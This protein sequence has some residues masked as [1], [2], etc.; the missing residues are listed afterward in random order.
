M[1]NFC[2]AAHFS[3]SGHYDVTG[4]NELSDTNFPRITMQKELGRYLLSVSWR[5]HTNLTFA[6]KNP[7]KIFGV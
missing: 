3:T 5:K 6:V 2:W 4:K 7:P 1:S